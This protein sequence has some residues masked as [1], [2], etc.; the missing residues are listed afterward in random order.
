[1][2]FEFWLTIL[3]KEIEFNSINLG[4]NAKMLGYGPTTYI[5]AV[6]QFIKELCQAWNFV[7]RKGFGG[8]LV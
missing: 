3:A 2:T 6:A 1:M 8:L 5:K 7:T 4:N